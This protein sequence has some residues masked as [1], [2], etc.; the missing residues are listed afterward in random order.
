MGEGHQRRRV[1][2]RRL[3][4]SGTR[5]RTGVA[6]EMC[7]STKRTHRE[8]VLRGARG[9]KWGKRSHFLGGGEGDCREKIVAAS[10]R[11]GFRSVGVRGRETGA[12]REEFTTASADG[13]ASRPYRGC[14]AMGNRR[15][16]GGEFV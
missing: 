11:L 5:S 15:V 14:G 4:N 16:I 12:Q 6:K 8:G 9:R 13:W 7:H 10:R 3:F 1:Q 2:A